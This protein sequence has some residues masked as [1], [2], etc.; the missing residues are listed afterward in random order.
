MKQIVPEQIVTLLLDESKK[1]GSTDTEVILL[2]KSGKNLCFRDGKNEYL[3]QFDEFKV[4]LKT[5]KN[6]QNSIIS[7]N[8]IDEESLKELAIKSY[9]ITSVSPK[10]EF[11]FIATDNELN[12]N[13]FDKSFDL[14]TYDSYEPSIDDF[15]DKAKKI[16]EFA[17]KKSDKLKS[18]GVQMS[19][20][21]T[22]TFYANSNNFF[23]SH[24][25]SNNTNSIVLLC[26]HNNKMDRDFHYSTK[27][28]YR[29]L[30]KPELIANK[31][32][33]K[34][35][36]KIGA[37]KPPTGKFPVIFDPRV[38][39]SIL[40]HIASCLNGTSIVN[41]TSFLKDDLNK[42]VFNKNINIVDDP[43]IYKGHGS[44]LF[45]SEGLGTKK[46]DL[47]SNGKLVN[48]L[49]NL[50][51]AKQLNLRSNCN[52]VRGL[53]SS[54]LPGISNLIMIPGKDNE[55]NLISDIKEGFYI[56]ELIGSSVSLI[57]GDYSRGASG[58]WIQNGKIDRPI[59]EATIA[60][61]L[62]NIFLNMI[63]CNNQDH[64]ANIS[65]PSILV[66]GMTVAGGLNV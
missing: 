43:H 11:S 35:L 44:R 63:P 10:D 65:S 56:T 17:L 19:W 7:S 1:N 41:G 20:T 13:P 33:E 6:K 31:A 64:Q 53:N 23:E 54:P 42:L 36:M 16:E 58:F 48:F 34:V 32:S 60:G 61:N 9:E 57:T 38:S 2:K 66:T 46:I 51:T 52:A 45:D 47:V 24:L 8:K 59:S 21:K 50:T 49:L 3:E 22:E 12:R 5:F 40:N 4:G 39:K 15:Q 37:T 25:K 62:K 28:H 55:E 27:V 29:D 14:G 30:E 26:N 18:D